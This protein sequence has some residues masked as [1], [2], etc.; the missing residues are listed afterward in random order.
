VVRVSSAQAAGSA[1]KYSY[2]GCMHYRIKLDRWGRPISKP[3]GKASSDQRSRTLI[4]KDAAESALTA[5]R[6]CGLGI[7]TP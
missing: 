4:L 7:A 2:W 6:P 1:K 3:L 5:T